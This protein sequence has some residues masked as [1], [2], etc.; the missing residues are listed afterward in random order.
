MLLRMA[1][2]GSFLAAAAAI[3]FGV[4]FVLSTLESAFTTPSKAYDN[5]GDA[6]AELSPALLDRIRAARAEKT[7]ER[8]AVPED[9]RDP[10]KAPPPAP[11][12]V[13]TPQ[14]T[15]QPAPAAE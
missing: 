2:V 3:A 6:D 1:T 12:P 11:A 14:P 7:V 5:I 10:F 8:S 4:L 15:E 13:P 9:I